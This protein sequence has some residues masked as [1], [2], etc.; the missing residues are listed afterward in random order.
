MRRLLL[1]LLMAAAV[2]CGGCGAYRLNPSTLEYIKS[3]DVI[4][5][6]EQYEINARVAGSNMSVYMGGGLVPALI[7]AS[8]EHEQAKKAEEFLAP[9]RDSLLDYDYPRVLEDTFRDKLAEVEWLAVANT[10]LE[11]E[12]NPEQLLETYSASDASVIL[13]IR[14]FYE[15]EHDLSSIY[16]RCDAGLWPKDEALREVSGAAKRKDPVSLN[17]RIYRPEA[18]E[19]LEACTKLDLGGLKGEA[20]IETLT[21]NKG[22]KV[23]KALEKGAAELA[24]LLIDDLNK[25][26]QTS[27][28]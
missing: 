9:I 1:V 25:C 11:H 18:M 24:Q 17:N 12:A 20:A 8:V 23:R 14:I 5:V 16:V 28:R 6:V 13:R 15:F 22:E 4:V 10:A 3:T 19:G 27:K 2:T 21:E 26:V 7:D